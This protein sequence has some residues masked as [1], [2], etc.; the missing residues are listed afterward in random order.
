MTELRE[1]ITRQQSYVGQVQEASPALLASQLMSPSRWSLVAA[2]G[3][4][5]TTGFREFLI[6]LGSDGY[7]CL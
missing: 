3:Y 7:G 2:R 4:R 5:E 1:G 6:G